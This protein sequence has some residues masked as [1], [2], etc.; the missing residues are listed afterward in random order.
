[1]TTPTKWYLPK[2]INM[3]SVRVCALGCTNIHLTE[4][5]VESMDNTTKMF[6]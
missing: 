2:K 1:M 3:L 6:Y 5:G 4:S